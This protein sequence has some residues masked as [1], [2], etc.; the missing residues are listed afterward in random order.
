MPTIISKPEIFIV[1]INNTFF[2]KNLNNDVQL[3]KENYVKFGLTQER[4]KFLL[5]IKFSISWLMEP[6]D[7]IYLQT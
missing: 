6:P 7:L 4:P 3:V 2:N 5:V 1:L